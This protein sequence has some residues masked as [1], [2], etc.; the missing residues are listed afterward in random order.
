M[1]KIK[2]LVALLLLFSVLLSIPKDAFASCSCRRYYFGGEEEEWTYRTSRAGC[3][4]NI[5]SWQYNHWNPWTGIHTYSAGF[6][7]TYMPCLRMV[8]NNQKNFEENL[9]DNKSSQTD[10]NFAFKK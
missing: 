6:G 5:I 7:N 3:L 8:R 4:G 1:S 2:N 10:N 9:F